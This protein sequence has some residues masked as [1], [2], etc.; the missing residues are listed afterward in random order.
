MRRVPFQYW[1]DGA[2]FWA[3]FVSDGSAPVQ[4]HWPGLSDSDAIDAIDAAQWDRLAINNN[5]QEVAV[6]LRFAWA[7][8]RDHEV[9]GTAVY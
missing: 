6:D 4:V 2:L 7:L 9:L 3:R 8:L 1:R 5:R